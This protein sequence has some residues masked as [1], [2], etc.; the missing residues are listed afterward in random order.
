[1]VVGGAALGGL[2]VV[3][4]LV[5]AGPLD[6]AVIDVDARW[7]VHV[8]VDLAL[9]TAVGRSVLSDHRSPAADALE[10]LRWRFGVSAV[11]DVHG[12][13]VYGRSECSDPGTLVVDMTAAADGLHASLAAAGLPGYERADAPSPAGAMMVHSWKADGERVFAVVLPDASGSRKLRRVVV[14]PSR[15]R[16]EQ[17]MGVI[18]GSRESAADGPGELSLQ[19]QQGAIIFVS[20]MDLGSFEPSAAVTRKIQTLTINIGEREHLAA[21][22]LAQEATAR[23]SLAS[24]ASPA[25]L[26]CPTTSGGVADRAVPALRTSASIR[27]GSALPNASV[28]EPWFY[29]NAHLTTQD[30]GAATQAATLIRG[31]LGVLMHATEAEPEA[32]H[33]RAG[34]SRIRVE[35]LGTSV[36][37]TLS[38]PVG[39]ITSLIR[40]S[41]R[42][43]PDRS[44]RGEDLA[45]G[46]TRDS[47]SPN[48][49]PA[50]AP[51]SR[52]PSRG[53][54]RAE[55]RP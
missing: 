3:T 2:V 38:E 11:N 17:A 29:A 51:A 21:A 41:G 8:D 14:A 9:G 1:M 52:T 27:A 22:R 19:P 36:R 32:N 20:A 37:L 6:R 24:V 39:E 34:L 15:E 28:D 12:I 33:L 40:E 43:L 10:S 13:T 4:P 55:H 42:W 49:L 45:E 46:A 31:V 25:A 23:T 50:S 54:D 35:S 47:G 48:T 16:L 18:A 7:V 5:L 26:T 30:E 53:A 44:R